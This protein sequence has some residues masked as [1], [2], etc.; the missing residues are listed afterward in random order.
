[1]SGRRR[2]MYCTKQPPRKDRFAAKSST[3]RACLCCIE[4]NRKCEPPVTV[5]VAI[6]PPVKRRRM[7]KPK[8][9][10]H[11]KE[12]YQGL[13]ASLQRQYVS[14]QIQADGM[15]RQNR[16]CSR[17]VFLGVPCR[18]IRPGSLIFEFTQPDRCACCILSTWTFGD[19]IGRKCKD[20]S[21]SHQEHESRLGSRAYVKP[22]TD[23]RSTMET[24]Q[25]VSNKVSAAPTEPHLYPMS[26]AS[27]G[28]AD[29]R[30]STRLPNNL[31][32]FPL[33]PARVLHGVNSLDFWVYQLAQSLVDAAGITVLPLQHINLERLESLSDDESGG[34]HVNIMSALAYLLKASSS[35][36]VQTQV[37]LLNLQDLSFENVFRAVTSAFLKDMIF[38]ETPVELL[39]LRDTLERAYLVAGNPQPR[40]IEQCIEDYF[41]SLLSQPSFQ[42]SMTSPAAG[43]AARLHKA[44]KPLI[45]LLGDEDDPEIQKI[46]ARDCFEISKKA[47]LLNAEIKLKPTS[48]VAL[49]SVFSGD[50]IN[51]YYTEGSTEGTGATADEVEIMLMFGIKAAGKSDVPLIYPLSDGLACHF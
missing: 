20:S 36:H 44:L 23:W 18:Q 13:S 15:P 22:P 7:A 33:E 14:E 16:P 8:Y 38:Q 3:P 28:M 45:S 50:A 40:L 29:P 11:T 12:W 2:R 10:A 24:P 43:I 32:S 26:V 42:H 49:Y 31:L 48:S 19:A 1:M 46:C 27:A 39:A 25:S 34:G 5:V 9:A 30:V 47:C 4:K 51:R 35:K 37:Q 17:C 21:I 41:G 6:Q